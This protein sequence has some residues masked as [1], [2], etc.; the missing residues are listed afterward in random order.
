MIRPLSD[1][2]ASVI[3]LPAL[4][5]G[6]FAPDGLLA[7]SPRFEYRPQQQE[8]AS[9]VARA[10]QTQNHLAIEAGT[11][12]GKSYA[13]LF[14][15]VLHALASRKRAVISTHTINLQE[16]LLDKD[17]PFVQQTLRP[18]RDPKLLRALA[19]EDGKPPEEITFRAVLV[20][21][22]A[23]Y[24]CPGRLHRAQRDAGKL[25]TLAEAA[26]LQ[27]IAAWA[28]ETKDGSL[29]DLGFKPDL[30]VWS[31][32]CSERGLC[33][34]RRCPHGCFYQEA[35]KRM[36]E[37]HLVVVN[38][39]LLFTELAIR[40]DL[41]AD[42]PGVLLPAF[43]FLVLDEAHT[44]ESVAA[45]HIGLRVTQAG[46]CWLLH[47]LWN[48]KTE[49][50]LLALLRRGP[51]VKQVSD[52]LDQAN[53]FFAAVEEVLRDQKGAVRIRRPNFV[54]DTVSAPLAQLTGEIES[55][56]KAAEDKELREELAEWI[57]KALETRQELTDFLTQALHD[58]VY[59][60]ERA[61]RNIELR[62]APVDVAPYVRR[63]LFEPHD[64]VVMTSATLAISGRLDYFLKRVG[65][66]GSEARQL[67]SPFNYH[68]QMKLFIPR[69]MP[70]PNEPTYK[71]A[72]ARWL[73][74]FLKRTHG[75][76]LV[77]FTS[78]RLLRD[79]FA[80][81]QP[82]FAEL[83]VT[84]LAQG[85]GM[86]RRQLLETFRRDVDSILFGT[87]SFWQ[88]VD[89][90]GEALS[91]VIITRLPFAVPDHPL[92]EA[93]L[94]AI[95]ARGGSAFYEYSLPE[96]VLKLR[97]GVG[98]LIRRQTDRGIVVILDNRVLTKKYG[99]VFL[100]SL[101]E[102]PIEVV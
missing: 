97:Q 78:Y 18:F 101:P 81:L 32:V 24:L 63:M 87:D 26:D 69:E 27:R 10:L 70:D 50:G 84:A 28:R 64:S 47:K 21:G 57:R 22:R 99:R 79:V 40:K 36:S 96:A 58:H 44:L 67:G 9:A 93:R 6:L 42:T 60:V 98:R 76:A 3:N 59:W 33:T 77:L 85:E 88:G 38:H 66:T 91:N 43:D 51:L 23:N 45:E 95:E 90:P 16:Q 20:K 35:R 2:E 19:D 75:K 83:G 8:M 14:P 1:A 62:A 102:C 5:T 25:F 34:P 73:K 56:Q 4:V 7:H 74:H 12:I 37:A 65:A 55:L 94:E 46:L 39:A 11:G 52:L 41:D 48:P 71:D 92:T 100:E 68:E 54:A 80:E 29:S 31:E 53:Q 49:K 17:I 13:Y 86:P 30:K 82:F 15:A 61:P 89:V 72:V